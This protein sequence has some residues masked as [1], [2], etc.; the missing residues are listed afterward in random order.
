M[1]VLTNG[2]TA[3]F[4]IGAHKTGT[5][6][7]QA[8]LDAKKEDLGAERLLVLTRKEMS[9]YVGY[10]HRLVADP[11]AL[12]E[13][14]TEWREGDEFD[15]LFGS[16]ENLMGGVVLPD[17]PGLYPSARLNVS[18]LASAVRDCRLKVIISIRP[19]HELLESAYLQ[20]VHQGGHESFGEWLGRIDLDA[21]SWV[22]LVEFLHET[23]GE[24][25]VTVIDFRTISDGQSAYIRQ[26]LR[27]VDEKFDGPVD[28]SLIK[29]RSVSDKGLAL[30]LA[31]NR[32]LMTDWQRRGMRKFL[33]KHFSNVDYPRPELLSTDQQHR[34]I[35]RYGSEYDRLTAGAPR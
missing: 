33:Q 27:A 25:N 11:T 2:K 10:G 24:D 18:A 20:T 9:A 4:H 1:Q 14:V 32:H 30:A 22:P 8:Y 23:L 29:N 6:V 31:A 35:D 7:V 12:I 21:I 19:Q 15:A 3:V 17:Q 26:F 16:Y 28:S 5:S 13:R 34:L